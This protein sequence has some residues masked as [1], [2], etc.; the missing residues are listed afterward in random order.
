MHPTAR[1]L[2]SL[3]GIMLLFPGACGVAFFI[4]GILSGRN[5]FLEVS[6]FSIVVGVGGVVLLSYAGRQKP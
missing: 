5:L 3:L 4:H 6:L 2:L 1:M